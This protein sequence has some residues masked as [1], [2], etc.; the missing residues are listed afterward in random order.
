[1][2]E[3]PLV[4]GGAYTFVLEGFEDL[5][6]NAMA[7]AAEIEFTAP[8]EDAGLIVASLAEPWILAVI[9]GPDG[10]ALIAGAPVDPDSVAGSSLIVERSD[11]E[12]SG[13]LSL[14]DADSN[15]AWDGRVLLWTPDDPVAYSYRGARY[16]VTLNLNLV[17]VA[18]NPMRGPPDTLDFFRHGEGDIVWSKASEVPL[19]GNSQVGNDRFLHG[20]PYLGSLGLY[21]HRA[22]FYEPGTQLFLEPDPLGPVD[23]ARTFIRLLGLMG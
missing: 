17:D 4:E 6:G 14:V 19:L 18:G 12:V 10:L 11:N 1:M 16:D 9:D 8:A 5:A 3:E 7:E 21:D 15:P 20:R 22:R 2:F 13:T 23:S